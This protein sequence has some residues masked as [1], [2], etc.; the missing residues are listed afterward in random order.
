MQ[1][2]SQCK[3]KKDWNDNQ[4]NADIKPSSAPMHSFLLHVPSLVQFL[5][6]R[7]WKK[8]NSLAKGK[9]FFLKHHTFRKPWQCR[10]PVWGFSLPLPS[11]LNGRERVPLFERSRA[12]AIAI[13]MGNNENS[14]FCRT[15]SL[16]LSLS[17][18]AKFLSL[19]RNNLNILL[20]SSKWRPFQQIESRS[21]LGYFEY[22]L[23]S[24][25]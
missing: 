25:R 19:L 7:S 10:L 24:K 5:L 9:W 18:S 6:S 8:K 2:E 14:S 23:L 12:V 3:E 21:S 4:K 15:L 16:S 13:S 1:N 20:P 17:L 22:T 11:L